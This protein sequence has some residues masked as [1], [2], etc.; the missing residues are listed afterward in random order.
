MP[1]A[2]RLTS[3][4]NLATEK[5][6]RAASSLHPLQNHG[7]RP[8][9]E[10]LAGNNGASIADQPD[11]AQA[12]LFRH[13]NGLAFAMKLVNVVALRRLQGR[14][15]KGQTTGDQVAADGLEKQRWIFE[16]LGEH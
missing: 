12:G 9:C 4:P 6:R 7:E 11:N 13:H 8:G 5:T 1:P 16:V 14:A 3:V 15:E 2:R 10:S